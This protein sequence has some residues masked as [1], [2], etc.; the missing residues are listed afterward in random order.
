MSDSN[1]SQLPPDTSLFDAWFIPAERYHFAQLRQRVG[2]SVKP[3]GH[4]VWPVGLAHGIVGEYAE[5]Y[6]GSALSVA[7]VKFRH[8]RQ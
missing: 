7:C 1:R 5:V 3:V 4:E 2:F 6:L 8:Q